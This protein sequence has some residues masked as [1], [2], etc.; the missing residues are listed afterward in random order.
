[1]S[2]LVRAMGAYPISLST[3]TT[4]LC[5]SRKALTKAG[6]VRRNSPYK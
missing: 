5:P 2:E 3:M 6:P 4:S 1:M